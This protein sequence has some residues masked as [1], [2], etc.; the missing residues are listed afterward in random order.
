MKLSRRQFLGSAA[1]LSLVGSAAA[2]EPI[3]RSG[4]PHFRL[5]LAAYSFRKYLDLKQTPKPAMTLTLSLTISSWASRLVLSG[6]APSSLRI[7]S[8]F[9]PAT[10]VPCSC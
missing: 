9:F 1:A 10:V 6:T 2:I 3:A 8:T 7:T 4:G 5:S